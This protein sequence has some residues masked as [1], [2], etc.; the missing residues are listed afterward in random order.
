MRFWQA[1]VLAVVASVVII[2]FGLH[3]NDTAA[4]LIFIALGGVVVAVWVSQYRRIARHLRSRDTG[5]PV[6]WPT[7]DQVASPKG[8][9]AERSGE[10]PLDG[11]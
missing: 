9:S 5:Q 3:P 11:G 8:P 2:W 4:I 7:A 1:L 10:P 6:P